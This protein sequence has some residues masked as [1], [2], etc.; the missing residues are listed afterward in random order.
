MTM[1]FKPTLKLFPATCLILFLIG[2]NSGCVTSGEKETGE[3]TTVVAKPPT[4][5]KASIVNSDWLYWRGPLGSGVSRQTGLPDAID[6]NDSSLLWTHE[7]QGGGVPV[8]AGG[9]IYHFGYY[10]VT[11]D[12]QEAL[13][14]MDALS[15]KVLWERRYSDFLSDIVYNRY[16]VGAPCVDGETGNVY[17]Q[18]STGLLL[19]FDK[20]G[21]SLWERSLME[22][23]FSAYF[24]QRTH[25]RT[26]R[27]RRFSN[28]SCHYCELG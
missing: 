18:T 8:A 11:G 20:D 10:G 13:V 4:P 22:E 17:F 15:G 16:G 28:H 21:K 19:G 23:F 9:R 14:C 24:S 26:L 27:G 2:A 7:I 6:L 5:A 3:P 12:L 25:W 1:H